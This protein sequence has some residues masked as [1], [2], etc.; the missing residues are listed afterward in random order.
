[1]SQLKN[2]VDIMISHDWP[3]G[4][5]KFGNVEELLDKKRFLKKEIQENSLGSVPAEYLLNAI[6]PRYWFSAHLHVKFSAVVEHQ[7]DDSKKNTRFLK[8]C[9]F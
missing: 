8:N 9:S 4:I 1:M 6:K 3:R 7:N 5:T 2:N